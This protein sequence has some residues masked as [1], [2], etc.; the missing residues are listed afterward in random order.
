MKPE[1]ETRVV[2][3]LTYD[4]ALRLSYMAT[5]PKRAKRGDEAIHEAIRRAIARTEADA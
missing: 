5:F 1:L 2:I 3:D 4:Q